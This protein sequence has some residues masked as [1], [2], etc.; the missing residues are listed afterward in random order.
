MIPSTYIVVRALTR[1][2]LQSPILIDQQCQYPNT[3]KLAISKV[4]Q[5]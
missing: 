3:Y 1:A 5:Q 4:Q 2:Y